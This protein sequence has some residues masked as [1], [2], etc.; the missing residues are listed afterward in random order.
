MRGFYH[1]A[2]PPPRDQLSSSASRR[3]PVVVGYPRRVALP[4]IEILDADDP[5]VADYRELKER[6]LNEAGRFVAESER[7]VRRLVASGLPIESVLLTAPRLATLADALDGDFP[8]YLAPQ[9]VLDRIAGFHV[10][11]G[12]LAVGRKPAAPAIPAGA[13]T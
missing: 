12:C 1:A 7:V 9:A 11:R 3:R 8:V 4:P 13:R 2:A 10:H 5:R 6:R